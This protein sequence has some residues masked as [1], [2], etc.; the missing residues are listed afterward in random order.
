MSWYQP[1]MHP[2]LEKDIP[3]VVQA[4]RQTTSRKVLSKL[5]TRIKVHSMT[6]THKNVVDL[7]KNRSQKIKPLSDR[8]CGCAATVS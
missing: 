5:M 4:I 6:F 7:S 3:K 8:S 1:T 2:I